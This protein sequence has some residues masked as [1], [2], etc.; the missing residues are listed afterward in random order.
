ME[1]AEYTYHE[2]LL[3]SFFSL[4]FDQHKGIFQTILLCRAKELKPGG[5]MV[6]VNFCRD[7]KGQYLGNTGGINMFDTF[8]EIWQEFLSD[9]RISAEESG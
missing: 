2:I 4:F 5:K 8:N 1:F 7:E 3:T 6:L 9:G